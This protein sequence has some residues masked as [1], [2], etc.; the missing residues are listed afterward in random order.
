M[1]VPLH[2]VIEVIEVYYEERILEMVK[3]FKML[4]EALSTTGNDENLIR[5]LAA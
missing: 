5:R 3:T 2:S 4:I 1:L